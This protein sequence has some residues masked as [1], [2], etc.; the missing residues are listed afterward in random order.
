[1]TDFARRVTDV[2][3]YHTQR[4]RLVA[5]AQLRS[6]PLCIMCQ[7]AG[8]VTAATVADHVTP[9]HGDQN[10][11]WFG[12]LQSLCASHHS[13][14]KAE[15]ERHGYSREIGPDGWPLDKRHPANQSR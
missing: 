10:S 1:M 5:K 7:R 6:H 9:H 14:S 11:F 4:W 2:S 12:A 3:W 8:R 15:Q 13:G